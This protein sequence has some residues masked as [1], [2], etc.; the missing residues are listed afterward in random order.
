MSEKV[1]KSSYSGEQID[2]AIKLFL[3]G[4]NNNNNN[5]N[6]CSATY[7]I[8]AEDTPNNDGLDY[9]CSNTDGNRFNDIIDKIMSAIN[10]NTNL[11]GSKIIVRN[12]TYFQSG[13]INIT[14]RC[15]MDFE[16]EFDVASEGNYDWVITASN[17]I[18]SNF[19][20]YGLSYL[21]GSSNT[22]N[23]CNFVKKLTIGMNSLGTITNSGNDNY[24]RFCTFNKDVQVGDPNVNQPILINGKKNSFIGCRFVNG[25][26]LLAGI[27]NIVNDC[28]FASGEYNIQYNG[29]LP[30][31]FT[32]HF[33]G[34]SLYTGGWAEVPLYDSVTSKFAKVDIVYSK[35][36]LDMC[37]TDGIYKVIYQNNPC[38]GIISSDETQDKRWRTIWAPHLNMMLTQTSLIS[39]GE[40]VSDYENL[41][42]AAKC[43]QSVT[44]KGGNVFWTEEPVTDISGS[45]IGYRYG[46]RVDV[47][48]AT[49]TPNSKVD[50]QISS[51]QAVIFRQKSL[52]FVAENEDGVVTVYCVGGIPQDDY[53]IQVT[54]TEVAINE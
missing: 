18:F 29:L 33:S 6:K 30:D 39:T 28:H 5:N 47:T 40:V 1:Y 9:I 50:M 4:N 54:V 32:G 52:G 14:E 34:N 36:E 45:I 15:I 11:Q 38:F 8:G 46:Q 7:Y 27:E 23:N 35:D 31:V 49:I 26:L 19:K 10:A 16:N 42:I 12:G 53:T 48:N 24:F 44:I 3:D 37:I 43:V 13:A 41:F 2:S 25:G 21:Y 51:E 17:C 20:S 22:F